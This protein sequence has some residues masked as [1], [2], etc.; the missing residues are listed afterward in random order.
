MRVFDQGHLGSCTANALAAAFQFERRKQGLEAWD[1]SR[2]FIYW[3][4]RDAEGTVSSDAGACLRDGIKTLNTLGVCPETMW[5]YDIGNFTFKPAEACYT[6]AAKDLV[7]QYQRVDGNLFG[8]GSAL[9]GG[10]PFVVGISVFESFESDEVSQTGIVPMPGPNESCLGG[11][12]VL[13]VGYDD[14]TRR[15][16]LL[17]SWGEG[18]GDHGFFYLPYEYLIDLAEDRWV[19]SKTE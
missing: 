9:A 6:E 19:I 8:M 5:P 16:K 4:E 2:L 18:W 13:V 17:N 7:L 14:S 12:A 3:N 10:N 1:P 15:F 11:H